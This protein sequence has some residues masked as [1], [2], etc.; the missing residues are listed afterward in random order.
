MGFGLT[1]TEFTVR[2]RSSSWSAFT[3]GCAA[4][5]GCWAIPYGVMG[6]DVKP[7][8]GCP[9]DPGARPGHHLDPRHPLRRRPGA[10][11]QRAAGVR[12]AL[13]RPGLG[14][15]RSGGHLGTTRSPSRARR[16]PQAGARG[17][18]TSPRI[19]ITNQRETAVIWERATGRRSTAP[20]SGRTGAP[21]TLCAA[22]TRGR[23][24]GA[25][26]GRAPACCSTPISRPPRSP[27]CSTTCR[28]RARAAE[29]GELAFGTVDSF[30]LWRLT[31]GGC[32]PPTPP[33]PRAPC[34]ST[35]TAAPGTTSCC[36]LFDVPARD[37]AG[38]A[39]LRRRVR[40]DRAGA[41]RRADP[42]PRHGR[43]PAGGD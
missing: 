26:H 7:A 39:R 18:A 25:G 2:T 20:S 14:G 9:A 22:L 3:T 5:P 37:A 33:T 38:G 29:R 24:R 30:L 43:R 19:G 40:H 27:G 17:R 12:A 15:A 4:T 6:G 36:A 23:A 16:W 42:D 10:A 8:H 32:T 41:A 31:G 13:S 21:P 11:R 1:T 28:A 34:C 35:S